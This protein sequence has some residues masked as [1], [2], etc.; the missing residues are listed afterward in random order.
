MATLFQFGKLMVAA[1]ALGVAALASAQDA[2]V[3][4]KVMDTKG[5]GGLAMTYN[6]PEGWTPSDILYW[7]LN[8]RMNP[9]SYS[10]GAASKDSREWA[11]YLSELAYQF[12]GGGYGGVNGKAP[13]NLPSDFLLQ[14]FQSMHPGIQPDIVDREDNPTQFPYTPAAP[15]IQTRAYHSVLAVR[16]TGP[17]GQ[18]M[19][20]KFAT[21]FYGYVQPTGGGM[22]QGSWVVSG[23]TTITGPEDQ[24]DQVEAIG[25]KIFHSAR[26]DPEFLSRYKQVCNLLLARTKAENAA[27]LRERAQHIIVSGGG[28]TAHAMDK[29]TFMMQEDIKGLRSHLFSAAIGN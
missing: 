8:V 1:G 2:Y 27:A 29:D 25:Q 4:H 11:T 5:S 13:P 22:Y 24:I 21:D 10:I 23:V 20:Q 15:N 26:F 9:M 19:M 6:I 14:N 12:S 18:H 28:G 7:N 16:F 17:G 3:P